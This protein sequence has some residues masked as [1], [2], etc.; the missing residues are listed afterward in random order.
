MSL[1]GIAKQTV[2]TSES[3]QLPSKDGGFIDFS[4]EQRPAETNIEQL[5]EDILDIGYPVDRG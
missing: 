4:L 5:V 2:T 3:G 1:K